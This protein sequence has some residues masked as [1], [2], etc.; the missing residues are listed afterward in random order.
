MNTIIAVTWDV[1]PEIFTIGSLTLRYY[2]VFFILGFVFGMLM[3]RSF[4]RKEGIKADE[5]EMLIVFSFFVAV[6]S[7]RLGHVIFYEQSYYLANPGKILNVWQGGVASHGGL[8]GLIVFLWYYAKR[9]KWSY[10]GLLDK[11]AVPGALGAAFIRIGNLMNSEIYG[12]ETQL[13]WGFI[14]VRRGETIP[15]HPTQIYEALAYVLIFVVLLFL[16][17][18]KKSKASDGIITGWF[19]VLLFTARFII[20]FFKAPQADFES[21]MLLKMGQILSI[22][23][24]VAGILLIIRTIRKTNLNIQ[25]SQH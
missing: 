14:F 5:A 15:R 9:K 17:N 25:T 23:F 16:Y 20:E 10:P 2:G 24:I 19:L 3:L 12:I 1:S 11:V 4:F 8:I 18:R 6:L 13:S 21:G 7:A 22:P